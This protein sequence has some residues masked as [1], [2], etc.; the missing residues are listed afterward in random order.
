MSALT[1]ALAAKQHGDS[2]NTVRVDLVVLIKCC[3]SE[4]VPNPRNLSVCIN[5]TSAINQVYLHDQFVPYLVKQLQP[6][7]A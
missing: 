5:E 3:K 7:C 4:M 2:H 6:M 1:A